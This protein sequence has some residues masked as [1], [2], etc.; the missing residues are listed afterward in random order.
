[1]KLKYIIYTLIVLGLAYLIYHRISANK[2]TEEG[3]GGKGAGQK[4]GTMIVDGV[5]VK[6]Q[7]FENALE[8]TGS[9]EANEAVS[10][11]TEVPGLVKGIY[12]KEGSQ[13][14]KGQLLVKITNDTD[15]LCIGRPYGKISALLLVYTGNMRSELFVQPKMLA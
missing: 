8:V 15:F 13:V 10:L 4:G 3:G 7:S 5:V 6:P 1:M 11:H 9:L 2:A 14:K 12:F